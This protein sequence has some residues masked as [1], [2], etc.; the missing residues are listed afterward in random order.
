LT[1]TKYRQRAQALR[2]DFA[3]T[4]A[5]DTIASAVEELAGARG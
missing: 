4:N 2:D 1:D 3:R 5:L